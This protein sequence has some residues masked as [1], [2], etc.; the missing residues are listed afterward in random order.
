M[1]LI[2]TETPQ[3]SKNVLNGRRVVVAEPENLAIVAVKRDL[4]PSS[5]DSN[6]KDRKPER[7]S[8]L[9]EVDIENQYDNEPKVRIKPKRKLI[10][11][12]SYNRT[13][14]V[15]DELESDF[16]FLSRTGDPEI[17]T[18]RCNIL[19]GIVD[20]MVESDPEWT[21]NV[22]VVIL[23]SGLSPRAFVYPDGTIFISQSLIN[24]LDNLDEV[25]AVLGHEVKHLVNKTSYNAA[26]S[27]YNYGRSIGVEWFHEMLS[28]F[29]SSELL[30]KAGFNT[31]ATSTS[32][33]KIGAYL[34]NHRNDIAHQAP[35]MRVIQ[36]YIEHSIIEFENSSKPFTTMD[37]ELRTRNKLNNL[38]IMGKLFADGNLLN[39][40]GNLRK[41]NKRDL[42][43]L[44][45][46]YFY[47]LSVA[48]RNIFGEVFYKLVSERLG[49]F[50][51]DR[52]QIKL[53]HLTLG[54]LP[55]K[56]LFTDLSE[57][58]G[59]VSTAND[60]YKMNS[61]LIA[62]NHLFKENRNTDSLDD[63]VNCVAKIYSDRNHIEVFSNN[64][65]YED[66]IVKFILEVN[67][68]NKKDVVTNKTHLGTRSIPL[69]NYS[70]DKRDKHIKY[71]LEILTVKSILN[72]LLNDKNGE[73]KL[74]RCTNFFS[75]L[76]SGGFSIDEP[77][78]AKSEVF[79]NLDPNVI[80]MLEEA[81]F[82]VYEKKLITGDSKEKKTKIPIPSNEELANK[83]ENG[84]WE[85]S[86]AENLL[87]K[88]YISNDLDNPENII[89]RMELV[90]LI[91]IV[92]KKLSSQND[93]SD[94]QKAAMI[95]DKI[96]NP[97]ELEN[98]REE[99]NIDG[100]YEVSQSPLEIVKLKGINLSDFDSKLALEISIIDTKHIIKF[101][102]SFNDENDSSDLDL[103]FELCYE[104]MKPEN[105]IIPPSKIDTKSLYKSLEYLFTIIDED[106]RVR[107]GK[108]F[109]NFDKLLQLPYVQEL[110]KRF[111]NVEFSTI[112]EAYSFLSN[113][114]KDILN[115][116]SRDI[117]WSDNF[118]ST[119]L[120]APLRKELVKVTKDRSFNISSYGVLVKLLNEFF[121]EEIETTT[122]IKR[123]T[124]QY[125][126]S[127]EVT[128]ENK[129]KFFNEN[130]KILGI[131][132]STVLGEQLNTKELYLL[133][134]ETA[135]KE[136]DKYLKGEEDL[137][138]VAISDFATSMIVG[139]SRAVL[140][141]VS[142]DVKTQE[143]VTTEY[144][145]NWLQ[146]V[147]SAN[148]EHIT[149]S[150]YDTQAR[151]VI[152]R[153]EAKYSF[154]SFVD[155]I[156][157][158]KAL[159]L[160]KRVSISLKLLSDH[161][162]YLT[163]D[164]YKK[165]TLI[166]F[167]KSSL[168]SKIK[169]VEQVIEAAI[170][171]P[172]TDIIAFPVAKLLAPLLFQG[173][174]IKHLKT[175]KIELTT[176]PYNIKPGRSKKEPRFISSFVTDL[177]HILSTTTR[178]LL[179]YGQIYSKDLNSIPA[180]LL[181]DSAE[182]YRTVL[183]NLTSKTTDIEKS[184]FKQTNENLKLESSLEA[185]IGAL[186]TAAIFVKALQISVQVKDF[187]DTI[188]E[189]L[190]QSQDSMRG[191]TKL[192]FWENLLRRTEMEPDIAKLMD[193]GTFSLDEYKGGGSLFTTY[194]AS[195]KDNQ[196]RDRK[197]VI[198]MLNPNAE[199]FI[200]AT[201][202]FSKATIKTV[203]EASKGDISY[204]ARIVDSLLD[205]SYRW[206][207]E[208]IA[209]PSF[210]VDDDTFRSTIDEFN[211]SRKQVLIKAPERVYS[212]K[213][214]KVEELCEGKTLNN[215]FNDKEISIE[216][217]QFL[218]SL[219]TQFFEFQFEFSPR[220]DANGNN[221]Y[222]FHSDPHTGNYIS[223]TTSQD[224][225]ISVIDRNMYIELNEK[226]RNV[227][228]LFNNGKFKDFAQQLISLCVDQCE[229]KPRTKNRLKS[230]IIIKLVIENQRQKIK[231]END[232]LK[233]LE[234]I[235]SSLLKHP[236]YSMNI[237]LSEMDEMDKVLLTEQ[238]VFL[239]NHFE[240]NP[241]IDIGD[242]YPKLSR[243]KVFNEMVLT[244]DRYEQILEEMYD[245]QLLSK[246]SADVPL[247]YRLMIRNVVMMQNLRKRFPS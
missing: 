129:I 241:D 17:G 226:E 108:A 194:S 160:S 195:I 121:P 40:E 209:D 232:P 60:M 156:S 43:S 179:L 137:D 49:A 204:Q 1:T 153:N 107:A 184:Q 22:Q 218:A 242:A 174:D 118:A 2:S 31:T 155:I 181:Q 170:L 53:F 222:L 173:L 147:A 106:K 224:A 130:Y 97:V 25:A 211:I 36:Q 9:V 73:N 99:G 3:T 164:S 142:Q 199:S 233:Y 57:I 200:Q 229:L 221:Q 246:N 141:T 77:F 149:K 245:K 230:S 151:K 134:R 210:L 145:D 7:N 61:I 127:N 74:Q 178:D 139:S 197:V 152:V 91:K 85:L 191:Q 101:I 212:S 66:N 117:L 35:S 64:T 138:K 220:K 238:E 198:K 93:I 45:R 162:G 41:L 223:D 236:E 192:S 32:L 237:K 216:Q 62:S 110:I 48:N 84:E 165:D 234:I 115:S 148:H 18:R 14:D 82:S 63:L 19:Q 143:E 196:E 166:A 12:I 111:S 168:R 140:Q 88:I 16:E 90:S 124:I 172:K 154:K 185:I 167:V 100:E 214:I 8:K 34:S 228:R 244:K 68:Y 50:G 15:T 177:D 243:S 65:L 42:W 94:E 144:A 135:A 11:E 28:D 67:K 113:L 158:L 122:I 225:Q 161:N 131:E 58:N 176:L 150:T 71:K 193:G 89:E 183:A 24:I 132:G 182:D 80:T 103:A 119:I 47:N 109:T 75:K 27:N 70:Y 175:E 20:K 95:L 96:L 52:K 29:G 78:S 205:L 38:E 59:Y 208:E 114:K 98:F 51:F 39:L 123:L 128:V 21:G 104:F 189:R 54:L 157:S 215:I 116:N 235:S 239:L 10:F 202:E 190:S 112:N 72:I 126:K 240:N 26:M 186:E 163:G 87:R 46:D 83:L 5:T 4:Q 136:F 56:Y 33:S 146:V 23:N 86:Y 76:K 180:K 81:Y 30:D 13:I 69:Y 206:C 55:E 201:Y 219:V 227:F 213:R 92:I 102:C 120:F 207:L 203:I 6:S 133:F 79:D 247:K 44:K 105:C 159:S 231:K 171:S 169:L 188:R 187:S 37:P 217:K 125:L